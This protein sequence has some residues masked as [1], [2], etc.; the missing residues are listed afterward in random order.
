MEKLTGR[1][2]PIITGVDIPVVTNPGPGMNNIPHLIMF[3]K[4]FTPPILRC[5][6]LQQ[7]NQTAPLI[8]IR[9]RNPG[10]LQNRGR[11][12][13]I[14]GWRLNDFT[15]L[16]RC[17]ARVINNQRHPQRLFEVRPFSGQPALAAVVAIVGGINDNG[18]FGQP[19]LFQRI[20]YALNNSVQ[21]GNHPVTRAHIRIILFC[22]IPAP[23]PAPP[24]HRCF[25]KI[26]QRLKNR[27]IIQPR[28]RRCD[29]FVHAVN[30]FR[31]WEM[32]NT[33]A[34]IIIFRMGNVKTHVEE[35]RL[36]GRLLFQKIHRSVTHNF[37]AVPRRSIRH[38][39]EVG[40]AMDVLPVVEH[41]AERL[42]RSTFEIG[43]IL[44]VIAGS[45]SRLPKQVRETDCLISGC[46][47]A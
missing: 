1:V 15:S 11:Q 23:V 36:I 25:H 28:L 19:A 27:R 24:V 38:F 47:R 40:I 3:M 6:T 34:M 8:G 4:G 32:T 41:S 33:G 2:L 12:I 9:N 14:K 45:I 44:A 26:R 30:S 13:Q 10:Q 18:I 22:R 42:T 7:W 29:L 5:V 17:T 21:P 43:M 16:P 37:V 31:P 20:Q 39:L 35:K 46:N